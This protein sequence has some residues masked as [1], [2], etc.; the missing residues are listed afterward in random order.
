MAKL[1]IRVELNKGREGMPLEKLIARAEHLVG[2]LSN[3]AKDLGLG[4]AQPVW[5]AEEFDNG[6]VDFD[7]RLDS[8]LDEVLVEKGCSALDHYFGGTPLDPLIALKIRP[9][10]KAQFRKLTSSLDLD[11]RIFVSVYGKGS[12]ELGPWR[13]LTAST[14]TSSDLETELGRSYHGE[15][16]G[17][18]AALFKES[19]YHLWVREL[20]TDRRIKCFFKKELYTEAIRAL[21]DPESVVFIDGEVTEDSETGEINVI[22]ADHIR[23]APAFSSELY[24]SLLGAIP[25][26]TG[27]L[28]TLEHIEAFRERE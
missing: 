5:L 26:Y 7:C 23:P 9:G 1:K 3:L 16:Q 17:V 19:A 20:S 8:E 14:A 22:H 13:E 10:T 6:S 15:I 11:E 12:G 21:N 27:N 4:G 28:S 2:F 24:Q 18:V 25:D